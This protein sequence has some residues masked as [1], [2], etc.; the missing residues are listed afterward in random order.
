MASPP[1]SRITIFKQVF[2]FLTYT[3]RWLLR[4]CTTL[5]QMPGQEGKLKWQKLKDIPFV[6]TVTLD[7]NTEIPKE[8][9]LMW[10]KVAQ[11]ARANELGK[12]VYSCGCDQRTHWPGIQR[13]LNLV[14]G[15]PTFLRLRNSQK[16]PYG[17]FPL[18]PR[19]IIIKSSDLL[20]LQNNCHLYHFC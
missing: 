13:S 4:S 15:S 18:I 7:L 14:P 17:V 8:E 5:L 6:P 1:E 3:F 9:S 19:S 2:H 20:W 16:L 12:S 10:G 11:Q